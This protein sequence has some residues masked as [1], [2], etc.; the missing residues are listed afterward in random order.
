MADSETDVRVTYLNL[1]IAWLYLNYEM[2]TADD[3]L[4]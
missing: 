2:R 4:K 1:D 3:V